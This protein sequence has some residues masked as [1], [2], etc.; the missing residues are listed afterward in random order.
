MDVITLEEFIEQH[1]RFV[2]Q[3]YNESP[4]SGEAMYN[5]SPNFMYAKLDFTIR[6][7]SKDTLY[8]SLM[9][10]KGTRVVG[11]N[12]I[13]FNGIHFYNENCINYIGQ[14]VTARYD[15]TKSEILYV[16][17]INGNFLFIAQE[18]QK[19]GWN[20]TQEDFQRE[21]ERKKIA[22]QKALNNYTADNTI[23]STESI[24]DRLKRQ[25][26]SLEKAPI[27]KPKTVEIIRNEQIEEN[28]KR[29]SL[30]DI[31]RNYEDVLAQN[32]ARKK[33][34]TSKQKEL[35]ERFKRN[36]LDHANATAKQA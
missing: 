19:Q 8:F 16:F 34:V 11:R 7:V 17:D 33:E 35:A 27:A 30:S 25:A 36:M 28:L 12:G 13:T 21:N 22:R 14:K 31:E 32:T 2:Y 26:E 4:H 29:I 10:V 15:P 18:V 24:G 5:N 1:N 23:R 9:R 3:I 20:L 6:R